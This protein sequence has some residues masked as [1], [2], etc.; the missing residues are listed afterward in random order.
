MQRP[1]GAAAGGAAALVRGFTLAV[2]SWD[3]MLSLLRSRMYLPVV[4]FLNPAEER[5]LHLQ[6]GVT[7]MFV[8]QGHQGIT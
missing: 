1:C 8:Q 3:R 4:G 6:P 2:D 7:Y 5:P